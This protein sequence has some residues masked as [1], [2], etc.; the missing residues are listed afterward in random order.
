MTESNLTPVLGLEMGALV[1]STSLSIFTATRG[2]ARACS[3]DPLEAEAGT[4]PGW[5]W[6]GGQAL[7]LWAPAAWGL[8]GGGGVLH[9]LPGPLG[10]LQW[11]FTH[12][13]WQEGFR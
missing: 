13:F 9:T 6:A 11:K 8:Q 3:H 1:P 7:W 10:S 12:S 4:L 5:S 2:Q